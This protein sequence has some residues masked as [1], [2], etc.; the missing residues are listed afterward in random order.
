MLRQP[1]EPLLLWLQND[2]PGAGGP[3]FLRVKNSGRTERRQA[4]PIMAPALADGFDV[5][6]A[7][8]NRE[9]GLVMQ[10][11]LHCSQR[12]VAADALIVFGQH[13]IRCPLDRH[14]WP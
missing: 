6:T 8:D 5:I 3:E 4:C 7:E 13:A 2:L 1:F 12:F 11:R 10:V 14:P 9:R